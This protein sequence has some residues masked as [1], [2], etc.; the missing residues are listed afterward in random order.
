MFEDMMYSLRTQPKVSQAPGLVV[1]TVRKN[2]DAKEPGKVMVE[3][4]LGESGKM[5][6]GFQTIPYSSTDPEPKR[7][8]FNSDGHMAFGYK[9]LDDKWYYFND[10]FGDDYGAM[11][12]DTTTPDG[13][14]VGSD[15]A[16]LG[17]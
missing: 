17:F 16:W 10:Q 3:Y 6:T 2:Y 4:T 8:Y 15:G 9:K 13:K 7:V 12:T 14:H 5:L 11:L 1:G